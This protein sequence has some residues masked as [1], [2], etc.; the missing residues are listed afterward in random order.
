MDGGRF[1]LKTPDKIWHSNPVSK[2]LHW[3]MF[4]MLLVWAELVLRE[5]TADTPVMSRRNC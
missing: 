1:Y 4:F 3:K 5:V 2:S